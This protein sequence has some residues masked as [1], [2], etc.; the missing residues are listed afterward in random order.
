[1]CRWWRR[2]PTRSGCA[3]DRL[4][5]QGGQVDLIEVRFTTALFSP[6]AVLQAALGNSSL[7]NSWQQVDPADVTELAQSQGLQILASVQDNNVLGDIEIQP[8]VVTPN[9]D[10]VNDALSIDFTVRRLS[11]VRPVTVRIYDL[12]GRLMRRLDTQKPLVAGK[13]VLDWAAE[14]QQGRLVPRGFT[15]CASTLTRIRISE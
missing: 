6:G 14:D 10:G 7:A 5:K 13:Y 3:L 2:A 15:S 12:S 8:A 11:G 9:S 1:M 4:V